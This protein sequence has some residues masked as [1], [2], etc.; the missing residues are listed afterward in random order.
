MTHSLALPAIRNQVQ[1]LDYY[2]ANVGAAPAFCHADKLSQHHVKKYLGVT[3]QSA[4]IFFQKISRNREI[5]SSPSSTK[6]RVQCNK[7]P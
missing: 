2:T 1:Q 3:K 5:N 7:T 4:M 6:D